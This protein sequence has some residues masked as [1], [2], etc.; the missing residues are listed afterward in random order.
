VEEGR[1]GYYIT[2]YAIFGVIYGIF[3][4]LRA[5]ILAISSPRMSLIIHE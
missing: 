3:A 2:F 4:F 5:L 1:D